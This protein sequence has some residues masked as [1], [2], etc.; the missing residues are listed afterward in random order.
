MLNIL[1]STS[2]TLSSKYYEP[3]SQIWDYIVCNI[4][5]QCTLADEKADNCHEWRERGLKTENADI[6]TFLF[7]IHQD[8]FHNHITLSF[9]SM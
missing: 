3:G 1:K 9:L 5:N 6:G 7:T 8:L 2:P 4:G